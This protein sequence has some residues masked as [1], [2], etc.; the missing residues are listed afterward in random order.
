MRKYA[1]IRGW[2]KLLL[3]IFMTK[4]NT[5]GSLDLV[6]SKFE[7]PFFLRVFFI[8]Q[9]LLSLGTFFHY[10]TDTVL[11]QV[12]Y[13]AMATL[14]SEKSWWQKL[15][16]MIFMTKPNTEG[17]PDFVISKFDIPFFPRVFIFEISY[18]LE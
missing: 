7:I 5:E 2:Q 9:W 13:F 6:I 10:F 12:F 1:N 11:S 4:P 15:L 17:S 3:M 18:F 8:L 14:A 16:L